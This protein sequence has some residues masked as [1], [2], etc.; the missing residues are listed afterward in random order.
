MKIATK[1]QNNSILRNEVFIRD[2]R[3]GMTYDSI[4]TECN[5]GTGKNTRR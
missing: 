3:G 4:K 2:F 5:N 1:M